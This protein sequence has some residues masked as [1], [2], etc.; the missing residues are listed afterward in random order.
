MSPRR[1]L[2]VAA[3]PVT[4]PRRPLSDDLAAGRAEALTSMPARTR[5][6]AETAAQEAARKQQGRSAAVQLCCQAIREGC[7]G[8]PT[9][10]DPEGC[11]SP[12]HPAHVAQVL[13]DLR[14]LDLAD[15][16]FLASRWHW[17][18]SAAK[19]EA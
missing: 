12:D 19:E 11:T 7:A 1:S 5:T 6:E 2:R 17:G 9:E 13:E 16:P 10:R 15:D 4:P 18:K 8:G 3:T 14:E